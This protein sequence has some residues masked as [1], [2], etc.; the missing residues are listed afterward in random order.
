MS[1]LATLL[2]AC[3]ETLK[4]P[5]SER[6]QERIHLC[7]VLLTDHLRA[8]SSK[9]PYSLLCEACRLRGHQRPRR[10]QP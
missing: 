1:S 3:I 6:T 5:P 8:F 7:A 9:L 4:T 10:R 2:P